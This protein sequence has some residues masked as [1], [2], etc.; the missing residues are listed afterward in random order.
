MMLVAF[1][2]SVLLWET[3]E[4]YWFRIQIMSSETFSFI[5]TFSHSTLKYY[6]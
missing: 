3:L 1:L 2:D 5:L 6:R 4:F